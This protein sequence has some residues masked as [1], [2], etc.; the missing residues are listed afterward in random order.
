MV[1]YARVL[2]AALSALAASCATAPSV[3]AP[4]ADSGYESVAPGVEYRL[5]V[6][7]DPRPLRVHVVR[8]D[9]SSGRLAVRTPAGPDPDGEGPA[10]A[11]LA[12]PRELARASEA[13]V[14]VNASSFAVSGYPEGGR[15]PVY[16]RGM[17]VDIAG[18]LWIRGGREPPREPYVFFV[19][20]RPR[21]LGF[22]G[23]AE[24]A[25]R[26]LGGRGGFAPSGW[27]ETV[28]DGDGPIEPARPWDWTRKAASSFWWRRAAAGGGARG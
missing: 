12:D 6:R 17:G 13:L 26:I 24:R 27:G 10:E 14:L 7:S 9:L 21:G 2:F 8:A 18:W 22:S 19:D 5:L 4:E 28:E 23:G 3:P 15:P 25:G 20:M 1:R 11:S 16:R